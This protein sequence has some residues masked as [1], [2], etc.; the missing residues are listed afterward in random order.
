MSLLFFVCGSCAH[1]CSKIFKYA[2]SV[3][4]V[5]IS[6]TQGKKIKC[7]TSQAKHRLFL[8]NIPRSWGEDG[9]RKIVAEV[10]PGVTNVQ[11]VKVSEVNVLLD[12]FDTFKVFLFLIFF[13][14]KKKGS[15]CNLLIGYR[16]IGHRK[17][18]QAITGDMLLL[19]T[20]IMLVLSIQGRR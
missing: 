12:F 14:K 8:S 6:L 9:L 1:A 7:S 3:T 11:L 2:S 15:T 19:S 10:G 18:A 20:T 17:R 13:I 4:C 16:T 5:D